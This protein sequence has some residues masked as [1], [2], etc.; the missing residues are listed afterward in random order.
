[1]AL[2][3]TAFGVVIGAVIGAVLIEAGDEGARV[4]LVDQHRRETEART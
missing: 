2:L 4:S 3:V 1:M